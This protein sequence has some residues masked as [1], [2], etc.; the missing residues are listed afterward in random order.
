MDR[1]K[2]VVRS[3][4]I[5]SVFFLC[6]VVYADQLTANNLGDSAENGVLYTISL[7]RIAEKQILHRAELTNN[8][9]RRTSV[10]VGGSIVTAAVGSYVAGSYL[11]PSAKKNDTTL[12]ELPETPSLDDIY[13]QIRVR[14]FLQRE[15]DLKL[16][17]IISNHVKQGV[18]YAFSAVT[19]AYLVWLFT[20]IKDRC[21]HGGWLASIYTTDDIGFRVH[22]K[23]VYVQLSH[24]EDSLEELAAEFSAVESSS[25]M[26][27]FKEFKEFFVAGVVDAH[28]GLIIALENVMAYLLESIALLPDAKKQRLYEYF[29]AK[30]QPV[31]ADVQGNYATIAALMASESQEVLLNFSHV[32]LGRSKKMMRRLGKILQ[33]FGEHVYDLI[34]PSSHTYA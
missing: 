27:D 10:L 3:S 16:G 20:D 2:A 1:T 8:A 9:R 13:K 25:T 17:A 5:R 23:M 34:P 18:G 22:A 7:E 28:N 19:A 30:L 29:E 12:N 4:I 6:S 31:L 14:E 33:F 15:E 11:F 26:N 32:A 24:L 21:T